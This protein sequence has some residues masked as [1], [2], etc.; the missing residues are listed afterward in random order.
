MRYYPYTI[1]TIT[2]NTTQGSNILPGAMVSILD[3]SGNP[4]IMFDDAEGSNGSTGKV[5]DAN[6]QVTIYVPLGEYSLNVNGTDNGKFIVAS[7][8]S[9]TTVQLIASDNASSVGDVVQTTGYSVA[10]DGGGAQW[11]KTA[12]TGTASQSPAQL[13]DALLNDASGSQWAL[14]WSGVSLDA[15]KLGLTT[16]N[17]D[18]NN[19]LIIQAAINA[20]NDGNITISSGDYSTVVGLDSLIIGNKVINFNLVDGSE[21]PAGMQAV[22]Q[23]SGIYD[24]PTSS[25]GSTR[26]VKIHTKL[27]AGDISADDDNWQYV[28]HIDG[29][30]N[31]SGSNVDTE[32][33]GYSYN[34][35]T[36]A[37][38]VD[39]EVRG[40]KGRTFGNGGGSNIRGIYSF[41]EGVNGSGFTGVLTGILSTV[42]KNDTNPSEAI[43]IRSHVDDGCQAAFQAAG[44]GINPTDTVSFG[45]SC[46]TGSG[47]PLLPNVACFQAHGGGNGDMFLGY[48]SNT[49]VDVAT[50]PF[51][52]KN[53][54]A[55][56]TAAIYS[57]SASI[58]DDNVEVIV[59]P[60]QSGM[61][62]VF[63]KT[64]A[65]TF[66]KCYFRV[67]GS[68]LATE[69]Y[70]GTLTDFNNSGPL[71][72]TTGVDGNMTVGVD[73]SGNLYIENRLGGTKQFVWVF[74]GE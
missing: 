57:G 11:V 26:T 44:A 68:Q 14:S 61:I 15:E 8:E 65:Q 47:Q 43:G 29:F 21:L 55:T 63:A 25:I 60:F 54:G 30:L 62:E 59:A 56:K 27:D 7:S 50:A 46:R 53:T 1:T 20:V 52:V 24:M 49:D 10:G 69:A 23:S 6:G 42:Y 58:D 16:L 45:Y 48:A 72:G 12:T 34:I 39:R 38:G 36:D 19:V 51:R 74:T 4:Q 32:F 5:A 18:S 31:E 71:T 2:K 22:V 41:V 35:G 28:H 73:N 13:G 17:S 37:N 9:L 67:A 66:G 33:R 70:S 40:I 64:T 3:S